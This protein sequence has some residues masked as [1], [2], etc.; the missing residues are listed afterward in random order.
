MAY[1]PLHI[2]GKHESKWLAIRPSLPA[3]RRLPTGFENRPT[4]GYR[5]TFAAGKITAHGYLEGA[6]D[7]GAEVVV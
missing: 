7:V 2:M 4:V 6:R 3:I 1:L 5:G